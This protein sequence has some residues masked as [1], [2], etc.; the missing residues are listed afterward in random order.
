MLIITIKNFINA[1]EV[2]L[3]RMKS[4]PN[5]GKTIMGINSCI[6]LSGI[7]AAEKLMPDKVKVGSMDDSILS[8]NY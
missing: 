3:N 6:P 1:Q 4:A 2:S 5:S 8:K 7:I